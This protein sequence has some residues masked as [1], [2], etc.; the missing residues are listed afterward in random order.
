[1]NITG[2][3]ES[4]ISRHVHDTHI[5]GNDAIMVL[6]TYNVYPALRV[7]EAYKRN[8]HAVQLSHDINGS[9]IWISH[10]K[11][12]ITYVLKPSDDPLSMISIIASK[13]YLELHL[14]APMNCRMSV[15]KLWTIVKWAGSNG[16]TFEHYFDSSF[17]A[18]LRRP[19]ECFPTLDND[20]PML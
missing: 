9:H 16:Y 14:S 10:E 2:L 1:M 4:A 6:D 3:T 17:H 13:A 5:S 20:I 11:L 15:D 18:I 12:Y 8:G 19:H 7:S